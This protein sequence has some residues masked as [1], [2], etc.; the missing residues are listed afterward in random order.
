MSDTSTLPKI[1]KPLDTSA[2]APTAE[3]KRSADQAAFDSAYLGF[4]DEPE[5]PVQEGRTSTPEEIWKEARDNNKAKEDATRARGPDGKFVPAKAAAPAAK[6]DAPEAEDKDTGSLRRAE[7]KL[8]LVRS[9]FDEDQIAD[10][11]RKGTFEKKA[12]KREAALKADDEAHRIAREVKKPAADTGKTENRGEPAKAP[13]A[14]PLD[15]SPFVTPLAK[16]LGLD[17][18]GASTLKQTFEQLAEAV[19]KHAESQVQARFESMTE[20]QQA[21][22]GQQVFVAAQVEVGERFPDLLDP[23]KFEEALEV[24]AELAKTR[25]VSEQL[26]RFA[27]P[28]EKANHLL[29]AAAHALKYEETESGDESEARRERTLRA[30][31]RS[32]V[33]DR[34]RPTPATALEADKAFFD[35]VMAKHNL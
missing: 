22:A 7:L 2:P 17:E 34:S 4:D 3:D 20:A 16:D 35:D 24:V 13:A 29:E 12:T 1:E 11:E 8:A 26:Q 15:V 25:V 5:A 27:T 33:T 19:T 18:A 28:K 23:T 14:K 10:M 30:H 32:T 21:Q 31:A 9:G 6:A